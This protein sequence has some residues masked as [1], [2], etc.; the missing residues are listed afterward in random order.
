MHGCCEVGIVLFTQTMPAVKLYP[1]Q[2]FVSKISKGDVT[3]E[4]VITV[5]A[6]WE[7]GL[8]DWCW[9]PSMYMY[10]TPPPQKFE[11][12]FSGRPTFSNIGNCCSRQRVGSIHYRFKLPVQH[13]LE[14]FIGKENNKERYSMALP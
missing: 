5:H 14:I 13:Y 12:N 11:W 9:C 1:V 6:L 3:N 7:Q 8:C 10:M 4:D 2:V